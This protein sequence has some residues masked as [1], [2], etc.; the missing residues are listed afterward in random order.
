MPTRI[1]PSIRQPLACLLVFRFSYPKRYTGDVVRKLSF[2]R[3]WCSRLLKTVR[4]LLFSWRLALLK[5][6]HATQVCDAA[7]FSL[8]HEDVLDVSYRSAW[9]LDPV[10]FASKLNILHAG[11]MDSIRYN[12]L[13]GNQGRMTFYA[14]LYKLNVYGKFVFALPFRIK[15]STSRRKGF[16]LQTTQGHAA[17][18]QDV[19]IAC[20]RPTHHA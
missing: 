7:T 12:L 10:Y 20:C 1:A 19:W 3:A 5:V 15:E 18:R 14:E 17:G 2:Q 6:L 13:R 8:N 4:L 16:F 11:L 9:K